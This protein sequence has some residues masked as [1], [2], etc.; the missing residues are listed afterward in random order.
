MPSD[1][2][3]VKVDGTRGEGAEIILYDRRTDNREAIAARISAETGA[4]VVP[5]FDDAMIVAGQGTIGLEIVEQLGHSPARVVMPC[6]G[7]G[8]ASGIALAV[9]EAEIVIV[10]PE[11]WDDMA[12]SL[13]VGEIVPVGADA[14]ATLCDA[15]MT[16]RVS[17]ITFGILRDRGARGVAVSDREVEDAIRLAWDK[18]GVVVEPGAAVG[19]AALLAGKIEPMEG[20]VVVLSGG[21]IDPALHARIVDAA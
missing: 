15:I 20:T 16:P 5:S 8:L 6:G 1:A 18:H 13:E 2:P 21:N 12:R 11:G 14:P 17:P 3:Q 9:P 7:G 19:L 10:E 4:T